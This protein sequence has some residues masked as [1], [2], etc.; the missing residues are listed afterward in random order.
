MTEI[1]KKTTL[2]IQQINDNFQ[3]KRIEAI[4]VMKIRK[5][6]ADQ[7]KL[8][9]RQLALENEAYQI[10]VMARNRTATNLLKEKY[11]RM[12]KGAIL[13]VFCISNTEYDKYLR[14]YEASDPP[15]LTLDMTGIPALRNHIHALPAKGRFATL[16]YHLTTSWNTLL[17]SL[18]LYCKVSKS[19]QK[20]Q[21]TR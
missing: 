20:N 2:V 4:D 6:D 15:R 19:Q 9:Q 12:T 10:R 1:A 13:P 11:R 21:V 18:E 16:E 7:M 14:G 8:K 5:L 17:N 3:E